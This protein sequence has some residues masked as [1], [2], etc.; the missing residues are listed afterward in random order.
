MKENTCLQSGCPG[1]C[2]QDTDIEVT[3]FERRRLFPNAVKLGTLK[4]L[5]S[6][7]LVKGFAFY[8]PL[9]RKEL[10]N[11]GFNEV[12]WEGPCPSQD[13]NG[14]CTKHDE[15]E[16]AA[17]R[18]S[19]GSKECNEVRITHGLPPIFIEPVE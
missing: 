4:E 9:K 13:E 1:L 8:V 16:Y 5:R 17:R 12:G 14:N 10:G 15:R 6:S 3:K 2:C 11:S 19:F 18:F 7:S